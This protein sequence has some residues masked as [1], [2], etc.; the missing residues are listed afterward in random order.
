[1]ALD[2]QSTANTVRQGHHVDGD[3]GLASGGR[4]TLEA[5]DRAARARHQHPAPL[6]PPVIGPDASL[7]GR[8]R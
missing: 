6:R 2:R 7:A 8:R 5:T 3:A 4:M 1:M